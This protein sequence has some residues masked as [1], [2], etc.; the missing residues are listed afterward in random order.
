[1]AELELN[2]QQSVGIGTLA[3][4]EQ[5]RILARLLAGD[6]LIYNPELTLYI[7]TDRPDVF[8]DFT[9]VVTRKH[10]FGGINSC[11]HDKKDVVRCV[12]EQHDACLFLDADCRLVNKIDIAELL[13]HKSFVV[14]FSVENQEKKLNYEIEHVAHSRGLNSP[15]RRN[16]L[17]RQLATTIG[18]NFSQVSFI[19]ESFFLINK[20]YGDHLVF[21][22]LWDQAAKYLTLRLF[23]FSEGSSIGI[24]T[25]AINSTASRLDKVPAWYFKDLYT[26]MNGKPAAEIQQHTAMKLLRWSIAQEYKKRKLN[27]LL[28]L[29]QM[30]CRYLN[31]LRK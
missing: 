23:E 30:G 29:L 18:V 5:Y 16:L 7:L 2:A 12:L 1:M 22:Q 4:G 26:N 24:C 21:L 3:L 15:H 27:I 28:R 9:N 17:L 14:G 6:L 25:A 10:S 8:S 31:I 19:T 11:Y 13:L 20:K